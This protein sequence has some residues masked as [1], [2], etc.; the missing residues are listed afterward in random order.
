MEIMRL[1]PGLLLNE[2]R[3]LSPHPASLDIFSGKWEIL[4][5]KVKQLSAAQANIVKQTLLS[6][7]GDAVVPRG[8]IQGEAG[9]HD[10]I[11]LATRSQYSQVIFSLSRQQHQALKGLAQD[12]EQDLAGFQRALPDIVAH[13]RSLSMDT[14][15]IMAVLNVNEDS[16]YDG[17]KYLNPEK[18]LLHCREM[19]DQGATIIDIGAESS[20][21]GATGV[22]EALERE[23]ILPLVQILASEQVPAL[24]SVDTV[25]PGV[26]RAALEAGAHIINDIQGLGSAQMR[27]VAAQFDCPV[28]VMHMQGSPQNMQD[29]PQYDDVILDI[30][31]FFDERIDLA[32]ASGIKRDRI[33]LDPGIGFG[34]TLEHNKK[35]IQHLSAFR[36][37]GLPILIGASRK[38]LIG[39][40]LDQSDPSQRLVGTLLLHYQSLLNGANILRVHDVQEHS[41]L[42]KM[43][44][45]M[46]KPS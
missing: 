4:P 26:A 42:L 41:D 46:Q 18:A 11:L 8:V 37:L 44:N 10:V 34:K 9:L 5:V 14:P 7:G 40:I 1:N 25:K 24:I 6:S 30:R 36:A 16:F 35:I 19:I 28:V 23:R 43:H 20:R 3:A 12:L 21:P 2:I 27:E 17:G 33:I 29:Q 32:L 39:T 13:D 15:Q 45:A 38:S 22:S 31:A